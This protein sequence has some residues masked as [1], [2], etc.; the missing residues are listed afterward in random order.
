[1]HAVSKTVS[2]PLVDIPFTELCPG[3]EALQNL[4]DAYR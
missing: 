4:M 3:N 1:M 2:T